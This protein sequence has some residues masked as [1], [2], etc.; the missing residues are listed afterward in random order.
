MAREEAMTAGPAPQRAKTKRMY[1]RQGNHHKMSVKVFSNKISVT[2]Y[3][4]NVVLV[5][6]G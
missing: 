1:Y 2:R 3:G 5:V 4:K 6:H